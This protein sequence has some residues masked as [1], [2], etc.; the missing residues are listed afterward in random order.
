MYIDYS[1]WES[2]EYKVS[3]LQL[4]VNNPRI[5]YSNDNLNQ[6]QIMKLLIENEKI[7]DLAKKISEEGYFVGEEP[8]ICIENNK[9]VVLEGNRRVASLKLLQNPK[10]YLSTAKA[11]V[12]L[13]NILE[14]KI[15]IDDYKIRC[16]IAPNR[17]QANPIIYERH[18]GDA[19]KRWETGNQYSFVA[20]MYTKDGL[21]VEDICEVLNETR[22]NILKTIKVFNLFKEGQTIMEKEGIHINTDTFN[23]TN[24]ERFYVVEEAKRFLGVSFNNDNG[25]I[26]IKLPEEEYEKRVIVAFNEL[27]NAENFS[28]L[29]NTTADIVKLIQTLEKSP[30]VDMTVG[31]DENNTRS[32]DTT[33]QDLESAKN[34]VTRRR[35]S[36]K[37]S[38][39]NYVIPRDKD[40]FFDN[41]KLDTLFAELKGLTNDKKY[42]F[43]VLLRTYLEQSLYYFIEQNKLFEEYSNKVGQDSKRNGLAKVKTLIKH[44]KGKYNLQ[45]SIYIPGVLS[46]SFIKNLLDNK[47]T[48]N[49]STIQ[50]LYKGFDIY[51]YIWCGL[52]EKDIIKKMLIL[53]AGQ[54]KVSIGH[55]YELMFLKIYKDYNLFDKVKLVREKDECY[56]KTKN[57]DR[58][59]GNFIFST[60]IIG[61]QSLIAGKPMRLSSDNLELDSED[62]YISEEEVNQYFNQPFI[63]LYLESLYKFDDKL[64]KYDKQYLKW[65]VKDTTISGIMGAVGYYLRAST[66]IFNMD[67]F[68]GTIVK[69]LKELEKKD[70]FQLNKFYLEYN[71]LSSTRINIGDKVRDA[72]F[73]YTLSVLQGNIIKWAEAFN[74]NKR[75]YE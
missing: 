63:N 35:K 65:F 28:R 19:V 3:S 25:D 50:E 45:E 16:H 66:G 54:R 11:N 67:S 26:T 7:Y 21:S 6:S 33:R 38:F 44:L 73:R 58:K 31:L 41:D 29:Y 70:Y 27:L 46:V 55:Q 71:N 10:K 15:P 47:S 39:D 64:C 13:K 36:R 49:V 43:S 56:G 62:D 14:N 74:T 20:D 2:F 32:N 60:T 42:A 8:I 48:V 68:S 75:F 72:I 5:R 4:D 17:L 59:V 69:L 24:L 51:L 40:I 61:I 53:N 9:K 57:G 18:K 30:D 12:L 34:N 1:A 52:E 22:G 37:S 23:L